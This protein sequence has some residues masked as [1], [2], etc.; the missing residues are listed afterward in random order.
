MAELI[1]IGAVFFFILVLSFRK[2]NLG[3]GLLAST[4][5]LGILFH[6]PVKKIVIDILNAAVDG[7]TVFLLGAWFSILFFS[8]LMRE[9]GRMNEIMEGF[10]HVFRDMR[11]VVAMLPAMIGLVPIVGGAL[12]SAPMVVEGSDELGLSAERRT[13]VNYWFRHLW[14]YVMPTYPGLIL[15]ATIL[16]IPVRRWGWINTPFAGMAI[17]TG[18]FFGFWGVARSAGSSKVSTKA[19]VL[20][21]FI[22]LFPLMFALSLT[23]LFKVELVFAFGVTILGIVILYR[24]DGRKVFKALKES[25][26]LDLLLTGVVVMS[27]K[28]VLE[29]SNGIPAV[30]GALSASGVPLWLIAMFI[31]FLVGLMT[32]LTIAPPAI[33]FPILVPLFSGDVHFLDYMM[34]AFASGICGNMISPVH[35]CLVLTRDYFKADW[36]GVYRLLWFPVACILMVGVVIVLL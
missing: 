22:N 14:E 21:L 13:F 35:L 9:A 15:A 29:S 32:G 12:V 17:V 10:R 34:L 33:S 2:V 23:L 8:G 24:I 36:K 31:P 30:S 28:K 5:L 26:S 20:R 18:I 11:V 1:K 7:P 19:P 25:L 3:F 4:F 27:F 6:L 16:G